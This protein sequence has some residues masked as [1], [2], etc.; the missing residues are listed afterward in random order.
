MLGRR[1][2]MSSFTDSRC[3]L[4]VVTNN[5]TTTEKHLMIDVQSIRGEYER[6]DIKDVGWFRTDALTKLKDN[7][8]MDR[9]IDEGIISHEVE[10]WVVRN[11]SPA[12]KKSA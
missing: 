5:T 10:Q 7:P 11:N 6:R 8:V 4:D 2:E 1:L 9:I 3:L 12:Q